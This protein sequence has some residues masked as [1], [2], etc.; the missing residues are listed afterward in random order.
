MRVLLDF[1]KESS[2]SLRDGEIEKWFTGN[3]NTQAALKEQEGSKRSVNREVIKRIFL[4][5]PQC[6][7]LVKLMFAV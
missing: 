6:V 2:V 4:V 3:S 7:P 5:E 1:S